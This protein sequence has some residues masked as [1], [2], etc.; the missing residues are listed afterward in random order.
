MRGRAYS[1]RA[2]WA[3]RALRERCGDWVGGFWCSGTCKG[4]CGLHHVRGGLCGGLCSV[5]RV[6]S[7][8]CTLQRVCRMRVVLLHATQINAE[9]RRSA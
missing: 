2:Y 7:G 1:C 9:L 8:P 6:C 4:P 3:S 5:H